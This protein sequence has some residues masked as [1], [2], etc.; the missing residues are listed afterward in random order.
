[1][2]WIYLSLLLLL[3]TANV[4]AIVYLVLNRQRPNLEMPS[5]RA[6]RH[7]LQVHTQTTETFEVCAVIVEP[8][9][10]VN[11]IKVIKNMQQKIHPIYLVHGLTNKDRVYEEFKDSIHYIGLP[12]NHLTT[13]NY[14]ELLTMFE[15]YQLFPAK[16][17]LVF[18]TECCLFKNSSVRLEDYLIYDY[19]AAPEADHGLSLRNRQ[20]MIRICQNYD[21]DPTSSEDTYFSNNLKLENASLPTVEMA[22]KCFFE[23][24]D[25]PELQ[26]GAHRHVPKS[27]RHLILP[28][29]LE[30]LESYE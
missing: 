4:S 11:L 7:M 15:F 22:A 2:G 30:L 8:R 12:V 25:S 13:A 29:E 24:I 28:E 19:V 6:V 17:I 20:S 18:Q 14:N 23:T 16:H 3:F 27:K 21:F 9:N 10:H 26:W 1:M 5:S